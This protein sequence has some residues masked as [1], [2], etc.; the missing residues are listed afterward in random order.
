MQKGLFAVAYDMINDRFS[1][2]Q[3]RGVFIPAEKVAPEASA[4]DKLLAY[5]R[6]D[7][8]LLPVSLA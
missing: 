2:Q 4:Q 5:S 1:D 7:R 8:A 6:R 3:P